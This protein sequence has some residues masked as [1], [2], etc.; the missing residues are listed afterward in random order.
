M[1]AAV[2]LCLIGN[3]KETLS[4]LIGLYKVIKGFLYSCQ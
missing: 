3:D 2:F 4:G 1:K